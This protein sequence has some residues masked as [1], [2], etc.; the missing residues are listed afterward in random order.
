MK[1]SIYLTQFGNHANISGRT[2]NKKWKVK[3]EPQENQLIDRVPYG[4]QLR[5]I[6]LSCA[7][8]R[9][10]KDISGEL[11]A[12]KKPTCIENPIYLSNLYR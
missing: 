10:I 7:E 3:V 2:K 12:S 9:G 1:V 5:R 11:R 8:L 4:T 6:V